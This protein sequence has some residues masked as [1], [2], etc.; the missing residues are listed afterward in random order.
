M[1]AD[2]ASADSKQSS[3]APQ[4]L[5]L[6]V[7]FGEFGD[8]Y[9]VGE[10]DGRYCMSMRFNE[11]SLVHIFSLASEPDEDGGYR[12]DFANGVFFYQIDEQTLRYED[13]TTYSD[14]IKSPEYLDL[15]ILYD[16]SMLACFGSEE[17][18]STTL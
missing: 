11:T 6:G 4:A 9:L 7:Y 17:P 12:A 5:Q 18:Y 14:A 15:N 8:V 13:R 2:A 3:S 16:E 1:I 10:M